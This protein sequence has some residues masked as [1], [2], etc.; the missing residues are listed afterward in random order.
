MMI[1]HCLWSTLKLLENSDLNLKRAHIPATILK[2]FQA[3]N[4]HAQDPKYTDILLAHALA[5]FPKNLDFG[6]FRKDE[7]FP[8]L[9]EHLQT[10]GSGMKTSILAEEGKD[11]NEDP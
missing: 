2:L 1:G 7:C 5:N 3:H 11:L 8:R 4:S 9:L 10:T 6:S